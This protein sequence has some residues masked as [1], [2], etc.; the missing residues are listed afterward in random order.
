MRTISVHI[1]VYGKVQG[2][3]Y[4]KTAAE[5]ALSLGLAGWVKNSTDGTVEME[6][7]GPEDKVMEL[8]HWCRTGPE[9]AV[10]AEV[11]YQE[12]KLTGYLDFKII[13]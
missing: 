3:F 2:V 1:Q 4:R 10:V 13:R 5:K 6:V 12:I 9:N 8:V 7:Q 11:V